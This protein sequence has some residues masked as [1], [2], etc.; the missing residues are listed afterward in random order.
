MALFQMFK[1]IS[2]AI[3]SEIIRSPAI[4]IYIL[5]HLFIIRVQS[6]VRRHNVC[7]NLFIRHVCLHH[8]TARGKFGRRICLRTK[9]FVYI[10][11]VKVRLGAIMSAEI[12]SS[13]MFVYTTW[14]PGARLATI[15]IYIYVMRTLTPPPRSF[16][17]RDLWCE[18]FPNRHPVYFF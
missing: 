15:F 2:G 17:S 3:H 6:K 4:F 8:V 10:S 16:T 7:R 12:R 13:A 5:C 1:I 14:P 11:Q 18:R 9:S